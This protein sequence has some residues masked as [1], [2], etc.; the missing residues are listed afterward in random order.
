ME[1]V[2]LGV[3][4]NMKP[5]FQVE[6]AL[7]LLKKSVKVAGSSTFY[8]TSA[9]GHPEQDPFLNGCWKIETELS[10]LDLK[11]G[12][13]ERIEEDLGRRR[14]ED[15]WADRPIDL[16]ILLWGDRVEECEAWTLPHP[17]IRN[18]PFVAIPLLELDPD[19]RMPDTGERLASLEAALESEGM[20]PAEPVISR[21]KEMVIEEEH[22]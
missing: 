7:L 8:W 2:Y 3:G 5:V 21:L 18:R 6:R 13:L 19:L 9:L 12:V 20:V 16:D 1:K 10:L 14:T 4:S 11:E 15:K 22:R 17:D